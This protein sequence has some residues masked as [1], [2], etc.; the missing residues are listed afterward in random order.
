[1]VFLLLIAIGV[2]TL[3]H[4]PSFWQW[5]ISNDK[6]DLFGEMAYDQ[7]YIEGTREFLGLLMADMA[8][9]FHLYWKRNSVSY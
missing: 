9:A 8:L 7:P 3:L 2:F 5:I 1:M 4:I 6:S